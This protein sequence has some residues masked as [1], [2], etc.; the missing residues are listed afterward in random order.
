MEVFWKVVE[1]E[2]KGTKQKPLSNSCVSEQGFVSSA[3]L[4]LGAR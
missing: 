4:R 3:L 1:N 2:G